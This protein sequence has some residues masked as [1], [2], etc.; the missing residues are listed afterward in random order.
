MERNHYRQSLSFSENQ[1]R[2]SSCPIHR[3]QEA[4]WPHFMISTQLEPEGEIALIKQWSRKI[5]PPE[6]LGKSLHH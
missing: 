6:D 2:Y 3:L 1:R 4:V 5:L